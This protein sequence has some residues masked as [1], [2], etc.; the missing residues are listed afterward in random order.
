MLKPFPDNE[1]L[2]KQIIRC[3]NIAKL[4]ILKGRHALLLLTA[5]TRSGCP[6]QPTANCRASTRPR[7]LQNSASSDNLHTWFGLRKELN[8]Q[9]NIDV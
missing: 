7:H 6:P 3:C 1:S 4:D 2:G 5:Q 9:H 8:L